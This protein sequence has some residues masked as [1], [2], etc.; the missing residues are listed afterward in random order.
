M[1]GIKTRPSKTID[2]SGKVCPFTLVDTDRALKD[3]KRGEVLE[4]LSDYEPAVKS[5]IPS[6]C[7][8]KH[9]AFE[10]KE[11]EKGKKWQMLIK[12]G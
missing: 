10:V 9:Y 12:K 3:M 5:T 7:E 2:I 11:I 8:K 6:M 1:K 4:V